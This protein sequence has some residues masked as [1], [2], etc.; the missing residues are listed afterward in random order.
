MLARLGLGAAALVVGLSAA[1]PAFAATGQ[2]DGYQ[3]DA[4]G[5][6]LVAFTAVGLPEGTSIDP[7]TVK[8]TIDNQ[9]VPAVGKPVEDVSSRPA[10]TTILTIDVSGS[11]KEKIGRTTTTRIDAAKQAAPAQ[12][13]S[14]PDDRT[15]RQESLAR[16]GLPS[17]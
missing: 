4:G 9:S 14:V 7:A 13:R 6:L 15:P 11:M 8:A 12:R 3:V 1:S 16:A 2:I 10:R 17:R 5:H